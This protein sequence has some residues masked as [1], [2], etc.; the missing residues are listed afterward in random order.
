M[1]DESPHADLGVHHPV[2]L[3][4]SASSGRF[5]PG[6]DLSARI[7]KLAPWKIN[8]S[9]ITFPGRVHESRGGHA[10]VS[11]GWLNMR[12]MDMREMEKRASGKKLNR[13]EID[14]FL[15]KK[16]RM[17]EQ[18]F[19]A[20]IKKIRVADDMDHERVLGVRT[21][22]PIVQ[23]LCK[24]LKFTQLSI[25][26][27]EIL[28]ELDHPNIVELEGFIE[29]VSQSIIWLVFPWADYGSL[30]D[31]IDLEEWEVPE[32]ISLINDVAQGVA[33]LHSRD[34][35][36][37]HGDLKSLNVLVDR[38]RR[39][40][41]TDFGSAR[42]LPR[43]DLK[44]QV[45]QV[46]SQ[47]HSAQQVNVAFC[48]SANTITLTGNK[49][50]L[51]WAAPEL[52][53]E[54]QLSLQS[55]IWAL[56]WIAYEVM[57]NS[58]PFQDASSD[59][60]VVER[61]LEGNLPS[62][63]D[64]THLTFIHELC[65]L[66][67]M[68][69]KGNPTERPTADS[70]RQTIKQMPMFAP[71][72]DDFGRTLPIGR[73]RE[74]GHIY[75]DRGEYAKA[76]GFFVK[77][78]G[79]SRKRGDAEHLPSSLCDL[80]QLHRLRKEYNEAIALYS[81]VWKIHAANTE[82]QLEA[83]TPILCD[84]AELHRLRHL[85]NKDMKLH[86]EAWEIQEGNRVAK[87][88]CQ[89]AQQHRL[90]NEYEKAI[91]L[92]YK[93][94]DIITELDNGNGRARILCRLADIHRL[95]EEY[96]KAS[97]LYY[98]VLKIHTE[99]GNGKGKAGI[100]C[101]LA[102]I[103]RL[104]GEYNKAIPL[105]S[106]ALE[107]QTDLD[108]RNGKADALR[109]LANIHKLRGEYGLAVP[110]YSEGLEIYTDLGHK[111]GLADTLRGLADVHRLQKKY[112]KAIPLYHKALEIRTDLGDRKGKADALW[113][114]A[115]IHRR[116]GEYEQA[117]PF[118]SETLEIR[119]DLGD[120]KGKADALWGIADVR[121]LQEEYSKAIPLYHE[122]LEIY[123]GLGHSEG[124]VDA[125]WGLAD[126]RRIQKKYGKAIPLYQKVLEIRNDLGDRKGKADA[127]CSLADIHRS[128]GQ[129]DQAVP[130][131]SEALSIRTDLGDKEGRAAALLSLVD[132]R[133]Y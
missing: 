24:V 116:R 23:E 129:Y 16:E 3:D 83:I 11:V 92:Y 108:D 109:G 42:R 32:R 66:M 133:R 19:M 90:R 97:P 22:R 103:H 53:M 73:L 78:V 28:A 33:Y 121:R 79:D 101:R 63:A 2:E 60:I 89:I 128:R 38:N 126:V 76:L 45:E 85:N 132:V 1:E 117:I 131:Y 95:R 17:K 75:Q 69:W 71:E 39:A 112:K 82:N 41:I 72:M 7:E 105:Y 67:N 68:C 20:T 91:P 87:A 47:P 10:A 64:N 34:P 125:L 46:E 37:C 36:I 27:A 15:E 21:L 102:D 54:D 44:T 52:L 26:E 113:G 49:Y 123:T 111:R 65:T 77:A 115:D 57:T 13:Q 29:D 98:K 43:R 4:Q 106:E 6:A 8:P 100:L 30:K 84:L 51:R 104:R 94:L 25:R 18:E 124:R 35:P 122:A 70:C 56:G 40:A 130:L 119:T 31:F 62:L 14:R 114:L 74:L 99:L 118:Y 59:M 61:V 50:T 5:E 96:G 9:S 12:E 110:L 48:A 55:D 120:R 93:A 81:E 88:L 86:S 58:I 80:A 127:L 107:I